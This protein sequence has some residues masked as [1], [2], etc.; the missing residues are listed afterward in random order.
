[1]AYQWEV[2]A[3]PERTLSDRPQRTEKVFGGNEQSSL[4][5]RVFFL[6]KGM[7]RGGKVSCR[8][9]KRNNNKLMTI[10]SQGCRDQ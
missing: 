6:S 2:F 9:Y 7:Y 10:C 4:H 8:A 1:M 3:H 5:I